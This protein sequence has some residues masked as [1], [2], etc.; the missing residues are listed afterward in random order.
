MT[1]HAA[2]WPRRLGAPYRASYRGC[3][4]TVVGSVVD[5][6]VSVILRRM[7]D[8]YPT[9]VGTIGPRKR[10]AHLVSLAGAC[11]TRATLDLCVCLQS[12]SPKAVCSHPAC[13]GMIWAP[14]AGPHKFPRTFDASSAA[15]AWSA[16]GDIRQ[17]VR[18]AVLGVNRHCLGC[19]PAASPARG[20]GRH[21]IRCSGPG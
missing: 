2:T 9:G 11:S 10:G 8:P 21:A 20:R 1:T 6:D 16:G 19:R 4:V 12:C 13:L 5:P 14:G 3:A 17:A 15:T 7:P 18:R